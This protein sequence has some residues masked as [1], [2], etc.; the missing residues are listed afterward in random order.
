MA[1]GPGDFPSRN[2]AWGL[3]ESPLGRRMLRSRRLIRS[4]ERD[5]LDSGRTFGF[6]VLENTGRGGFE[7]T[8]RLS[9]EPE[10]YRRTTFITRAE[11]GY[12][13]GNPDLEPLLRAG[14]YLM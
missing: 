10:T 8:I 3:Y 6:R 12:L 2:R 13:L 5:L 7:I 4:L 14:C 1:I 11:Y 9:C